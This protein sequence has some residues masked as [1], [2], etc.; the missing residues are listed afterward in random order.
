MKYVL[1]SIIC[2]TFSTTNYISYAN[3]NLSKV[4]HALG[5]VKIEF[6]ELPSLV[7]AELSSDKWKGWK[8]QDPIFF[9]KIHNLEFYEIT[10]KGKGGEFKVLKLDNEGKDLN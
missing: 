3:S 5:K 10:L 8:V 7:K 4:E 1:L 6:Q 9:V 2:L